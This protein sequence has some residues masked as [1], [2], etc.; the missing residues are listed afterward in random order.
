MKRGFLLILLLL[1]TVPT[2]EIMSQ[3]AFDVNLT[4][5]LTSSDVESH[6][7]TLTTT[8]GNTIQASFTA[9]VS[10]A[11][12]IA[13][14]NGPNAT[15]VPAPANAAG[16]T[17]C[18]MN[19]AFNTSTTDANGINYSNTATFL[20]ECGASPT[21]R[22]DPDACAGRCPTGTGTT[23]RSQSWPRARR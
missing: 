8:T 23:R 6:S 17:P 22:A 11:G 3:E 4:R 18:L 10:G 9:S 7:A 15:S 13:C 5:S 16:F 1:V 14:E 12:S 21:R 20:K 2:E 19:A